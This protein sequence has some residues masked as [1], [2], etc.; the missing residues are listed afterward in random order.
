MRTFMVGITRWL[1]NVDENAV[2]LTLLSAKF[3]S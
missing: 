2:E 1:A 3:S